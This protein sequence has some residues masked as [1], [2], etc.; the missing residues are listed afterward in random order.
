MSETEVF[1]ELMEGSTIL[2]KQGLSR[3]TE[4][5]ILGRW[6]ATLP[7]VCVHL[8]KSR[9]ADQE[10]PPQPL[11]ILHVVVTTAIYKR[12]NIIDT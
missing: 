4:E 12:S 11:R 9:R 10:S 5:Q 1:I 7:D 8:H 3:G 2:N 6:L